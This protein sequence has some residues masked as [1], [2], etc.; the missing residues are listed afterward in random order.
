MPTVFH[1]A[2]GNIHGFI[3]LRKAIPSSDEDVAACVEAL[4]LLLSEARRH[5]QGSPPYRPAVG[6]MLLNREGKVFVGQRLDSTLEAWQMPQGGLDAGEDA[7]GRRLSRARG[8]DRDPPRQGRDRRALPGDEL[9]YDLPE[10]LVG[11]MWR[12]QWR[13]QRQTWFL[14]RFLGPTPTSTSRHPRSRI[15]RLEMGRPGRPPGDDRAVQE[16]AVRGRARGVRGSGFESRLPGES[17]DDG[18]GCIP[19]SR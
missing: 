18:V 13:G 7:A 19:I 16:G 4:K 6:V 15:P 11:K 5:E 2:K 10:D 9:D 8:G 12:G 17:R 14:M 1:E 3:N